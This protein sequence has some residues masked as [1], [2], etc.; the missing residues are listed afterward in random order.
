MPVW[1]TLVQPDQGS[2]TQRLQEPRVG[3]TFLDVRIL[4][5]AS[6]IRELLGLGRQ[7]EQEAHFGLREQRGTNAQ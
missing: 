3:S 5:S 2:E 7:S 4:K 1:F 6:K